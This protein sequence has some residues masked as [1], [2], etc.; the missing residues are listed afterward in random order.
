M[1]TVLVDKLLEQTE[2]WGRFLLI[3]YLNRAREIEVMSVLDI[4]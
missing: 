2:Q 1:G 4:F 3:N